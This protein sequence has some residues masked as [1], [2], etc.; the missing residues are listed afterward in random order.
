MIRF[1]FVHDKA[2]PD[3]PMFGI[4]RWSTST[5][6]YQK[7][8]RIPTEAGVYVFLCGHWFSIGVLWGIK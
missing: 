5:D 1:H 7:M 8:I 2:L 3:D 6:P 4:A